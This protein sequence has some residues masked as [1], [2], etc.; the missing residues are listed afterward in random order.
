MDY[1]Q[2]YQKAGH[3]ASEV[4][5]TA[6]ATNHI[7]KTLLDICY[8][9]ENKI[10]VLGG[11]PAFPVNVSLNEVAAHYTAE[12]YDKTEVKDGDVL[13]ID[14]GVQIDGYI[15]DTAVTVC[16]N[17][18][19]DPLVRASE[20][21]LA[22]AMRYAT[23]N[24]RVS[25]I[26]KVIE[27]TIVKFG[28]KPIQ[29]LSGHSLDQY[30]I[31]AGKSIPNIRTIG[32]SF[33]LLENQ[34]YAIEPFVTTKNGHGVVFEGKTKN[35]FAIRSRKP[36]KDKKADSILETIWNTYKSLPFA[37]RWLMDRYEATEVLNSIDVLIAKKNIHAYPILVETQGQIVAQS[38]HTIIPKIDHVDIITR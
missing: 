35:I 3:I 36:S 12:P 5:E 23:A 19:Y 6:R 17:S 32:S 15:A 14:I 24:A 37:A 4:R 1:L 11:L 26:G 31:H 20:A 29:N 16:Y 28:F 22:E 30:T 2:C 8:S 33:G 38:E 25:E 13:K 9:L 18:K 21:A 34:A 7:G 10:K 27:N